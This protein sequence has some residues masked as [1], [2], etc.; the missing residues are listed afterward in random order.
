MCSSDH[1]Y[2]RQ[3]RDSYPVCLWKDSIACI[4][5]KSN[6]SP[7][8]GDRKA[9]ISVYRRWQ[10]AFQKRIS[11]GIVF[12]GGREVNG[13]VA[14]LAVRFVMHHNS[15]T[16]VVFQSVFWKFLVEEDFRR[17]S[18]NQRSRKLVAEHFGGRQFYFDFFFFFFFFKSLAII[19]R[20][21]E[22][23]EFGTYVI[24]CFILI[25]SNKI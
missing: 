22:W 10:G 3:V 16:F 13:L 5:K 11:S 15:T 17:K 6:I 18:G 21:I 8:W 7:E 1:W 14:K 9:N 12:T 23:K 25:V 19:A 2:F 4:R 24:N 20:M